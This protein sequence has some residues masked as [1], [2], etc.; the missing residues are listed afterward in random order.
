MIIP[1]TVLALAWFIVL[2]HIHVRRVRANKTSGFAHTFF[3]ETTQFLFRLLVVGAAF[4]TLAV[5]LMGLNNDHSKLSTL[6]RLQAGV[7]GS[8]RGLRFVGLTPGTTFALLLLMYG[9]LLLVRY[10]RIKWPG[11]LGGEVRPRIARAL[12]GLALFAFIV[13]FASR[14]GDA[15]LDPTARVREI[16]EGYAAYHAELRQELGERVATRGTEMLRAESADLRAIDGLRDSLWRARDAVLVA[17]AA[18]PVQAGRP[19]RVARVDT[20]RPTWSDAERQIIRRLEGA[21]ALSSV[22][23][24][25]AGANA[26]VP[27]SLSVQR[28]RDLRDAIARERERRETERASRG[29]VLG[30]AVSRIGATVIT[31]SLGDVS[32]TVIEADLRDRL[33]DFA[34]VDPTLAHVPRLFLDATESRVRARFADQSLAVIREQAESDEPLPTVLTTAAQRVASELRPGSLEASVWVALERQVRAAIDD[35]R[36]RARAVDAARRTATEAA[37]APRVAAAPRT[38]A[39]DSLRA[40]RVDTLWNEL[41]GLWLASDA[42]GQS[43][44]VDVRDNEAL[45][46]EATRVLGREADTLLTLS[47]SADGLRVLSESY[48]NY[49][50]DLGDERAERELADLVQAAKAESSAARRVQIITTR[51]LQRVPQA[52]STGLVAR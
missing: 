7:D 26:D 38:P 31:M 20:V 32:R 33:A 45:R 51:V 16:R 1:V 14:V 28:I 41:V 34:R 47:P 22:A 46:R 8:E 12:P 50:R 37:A 3:R 36:S 29:V 24:E 35:A 11:R 44:T 5:L 2:N 43:F 39:A 25:A 27:R 52:L 40:Q 48:N 17:Y 15:S 42:V 21:D 6:E 30:D 13:F 10:E 19:I 23:R 4:S 9:L 18:A 49:V